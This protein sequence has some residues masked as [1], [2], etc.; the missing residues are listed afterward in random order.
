MLAAM[1]EARVDGER[2][3]R[4]VDIQITEDDYLFNQSSEYCSVQV[5]PRYKSMY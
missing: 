2:A 4:S 3:V 1:N 5:R